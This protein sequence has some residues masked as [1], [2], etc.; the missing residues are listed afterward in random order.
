ML[1]FSRPELVLFRDGHAAMLQV[2]VYQGACLVGD[3][4]AY[5]YRNGQ[6]TW[7][8]PGQSAKWVEA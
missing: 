8:L 7:V 2:Y 5:V 4:T 3:P 6:L 1:N